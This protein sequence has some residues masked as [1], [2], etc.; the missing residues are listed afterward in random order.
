M[1]VAVAMGGCGSADGPSDAQAAAGPADRAYIARSVRDPA[2]EKVD[3][4]NGVMPA[5]DLTDDEIDDLVAY[6]ETLD[7]P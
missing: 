5:Y 7:E 4:Y 2:A 6:L 3:G 1:L